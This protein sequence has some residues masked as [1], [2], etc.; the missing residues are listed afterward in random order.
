MQESGYLWGEKGM[1]PKSSI[2]SYYHIYNA[3]FL[4]LFGKK[5]G[6]HYIILCT[7]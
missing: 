2:E 1:S 4:K 3:L 7:S 6:A 5:I